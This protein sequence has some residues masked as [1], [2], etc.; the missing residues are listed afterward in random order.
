MKQK[1][2]TTIHEMRKT[3]ETRKESGKNSEKTDIES[4]SVINF[5]IPEIPIKRIHEIYKS[6]DLLHSISTPDLIK[7]NAREEESLST[8]LFENAGNKDTV[9]LNLQDKVVSKQLIFE[10]DDSRNKPR[11]DY[12][13]F[14]DLVE[15]NDVNSSISRQDSVLTNAVSQQSITNE[16]KTIKSSCSHNSDTSENVSSNINS[17]KSETDR[18]P[19]LSSERKKTEDNIFKSLSMTEISEAIDTIR[20]PTEAEINVNS[21]GEAFQSFSAENVSLSFSRKLDYIGLNSQNLNDDIIT[22]ESDL[23]RLSEMMLQISQKSVSKVKRLD[24]EEDYYSE[25]RTSEDISK[26][27]PATESIEHQSNECFLKHSLGDEGESIEDSNSNNNNVD[28]DVN[29]DDGRNEQHVVTDMFQTMSTNYNSLTS[30]TQKIDYNARS[31]EMLN[32]IEKCIISDHI[33]S[34]EIQSQFSDHTF[35]EGMRN[36]SSEGQVLSNDLTSLDGDIKSVSEIISEASQN[37]NTF[38]KSLNDTRENEP[39]QYCADDT[40]KSKTISGSWRNSGS[41]SPEKFNTQD[42]SKINVINI[43][44]EDLEIPTSCVSNEETNFQTRDLLQS[45]MQVSND[46]G[47]RK[48]GGYSD[49][50]Q[51]E[52]STDMSQCECVE[53]HIEIEGMCIEKVYVCDDW[54]ISDSFELHNME[55]KCRRQKEDHSSGLFVAP[56]EKQP[57]NFERRENSP[58]AKKIVGHYDNLTVEID[59]IGNDL[60]FI[61]WGESTNIETLDVNFENVELDDCLDKTKPKNKEDQAQT[62]L[63]K[64]QITD[65]KNLSFELSSKMNQENCKDLRIKENICL[66]KETDQIKEG[67]QQ[68]FIPRCLCSELETEY[69]KDHGLIEPKLKSRVLFPGDF[70]TTSEDNSTQEN[71][72]VGRVKISECLRS[73]EEQDSSEGEQLDNFVEVAED[74]LE[75]LETVNEELSSNS[76]NLK[77]IGKNITDNQK[78]FSVLRNP[79]YEDISEESLGISLILENTQSHTPRESMPKKYKAVRKSEDVAII[80]DEILTK[81]VSKIDHLAVNFDIESR[82]HQLLK[83]EYERKPVEEQ[84][85]ISVKVSETDESSESSEGYVQRNAFENSVAVQK[86]PNDSRLDIDS[87]DDDLLSSISNHQNLESNTDFPVTPIVTNAEQ[88]ITAMIDKLKGENIFTT[89][90]A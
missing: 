19:P 8:S 25:K 59:D 69:S 87:L 77:K 90:Y 38:D 11:R 80:L 30:S 46:R 23:K 18:I 63:T 81:S 49:H 26:Y 78:A 40:T 45:T 64:K 48:A 34:L 85:E 68:L 5:K 2:D 75:T 43:M 20:N 54:T 47:E 73:L 24:D 83:Y 62:N 53:E 3:L 21:V 50:V 1:Y 42:S 82:P 15:N 27:L 89:L 55:E 52:S 79:Q 72:L 7:N 10:E 35:E 60:M 57:M 4:K 31:K 17:Q 29:Y 58:V 71:I 37:K 6:S 32:E 28:D 61:P 33:K 74:K 36:L 86:D 22:L 51:V 39:R 16:S 41:E 65:E 44:T 9:H 12:T 88:D 66:C 13:K 14:N 76:E 67:L 70:E 56:K 84:E